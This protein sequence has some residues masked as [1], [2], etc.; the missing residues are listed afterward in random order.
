MGI[1]EIDAGDGGVPKFANTSSSH[2]RVSRTK[3]GVCMSRIES[4]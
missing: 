1:N 3:L 4:G 2:V